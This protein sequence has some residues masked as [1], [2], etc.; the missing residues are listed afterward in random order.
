MCKRDQGHFWCGT[1]VGNLGVEKKAGAS[2]CYNRQE[3]ELHFSK[4]GVLYAEYVLVSTIPV[5]ER[6]F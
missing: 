5:A 4:F 3:G 1:K 6:N 2:L